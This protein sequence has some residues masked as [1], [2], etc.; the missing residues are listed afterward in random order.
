MLGMLGRGASGV[1]LKGI[2]IPT[3][4]IVAVKT[5]AVYEQDKRHQMIKELKAL[6]AN[7]APIDQQNECSNQ[8]RPSVTCPHIVAFY[9]AFMDPREGNV[10]IV[11]QT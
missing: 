3:M 5:I 8:K 4:R 7:L 6:Y 10:S 2:H 9:D 1:V 11:V